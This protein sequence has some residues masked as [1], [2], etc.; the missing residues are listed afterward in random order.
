MVGASDGKTVQRDPVVVQKITVQGFKSFR[1]RTDIALAPLT[2]L[3]GSNSS[4]KSSAMQPLLLLKQTIEAPFDPG[5]LRID[6]PIVRFSDS[7][8][9]LWR[10]GAGPNAAEFAFGIG[11]ID[12]TI[13]SRFVVTASGVQ[14]NAIRVSD[15]DKHV[16]ISGKTN[17]KALTA[18]RSM[19]LRG[20]TFELSDLIFGKDNYKL[21]ARP[22]GFSFH[23]VAQ[24]MPKGSSSDVVLPIIDPW[25]KYRSSL[26]GLL[27]VEGLRGNPERAYP[28]I[29]APTQFSGSFQREYV[30][31]LLWTW[32]ATGDVRL[33]ELTQQLR[34]LGLTWKVQ[35]RKISEIAVEI[36]VGR[37]PRP[38]RGG[39][40]DLVNIADVGFG[41]SQVL[42]VLVA[43]LTAEAGRI[44]L[45][46]QPE[47]HLHPLA[48]VHFA[49][50]LAAAIRRGVRVVAETHSPYILRAIQ[51]AVAEKRINSD[52]VVLH[53]FERDDE[54]ATQVTSGS[55]DV[56]GTYG[57][58]PIDFAD[59]QMEIEDRLLNA[60]LSTATRSFEALR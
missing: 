17:S 16:T 57:D 18:L 21:S 22:Q 3:S 24:G 44:V 9:L 33:N 11:T 37:S 6:G 25:D 42:P 2:I 28:L 58:W 7:K 34:L 26:V 10:S 15:A 14:L 32:Q 52:D 1:D 4:G 30:A 54:G 36:R 35:L 38:R 40:Q 27:H 48:Q 60:G 53:W 47:L 50:V 29:P 39:A 20:E 41:V 51:A 31:G 5:P 49:E 12:A 19:N 8:Q 59:V 55:L 13:E 56:G 43:L 46:E 45:I 23:I